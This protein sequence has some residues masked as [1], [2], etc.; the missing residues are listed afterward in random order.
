MASYYIFF[1]FL[2]PRIKILKV[3]E[4]NADLVAS[5]KKKLASTLKTSKPPG[6]SILMERLKATKKEPNTVKSPKKLRLELGIFL[7][8]LLKLVVF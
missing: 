3:E 8:L 7:K 1:W 2:G 5:I 6:G 4:L